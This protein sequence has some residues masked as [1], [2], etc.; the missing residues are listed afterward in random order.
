MT[1]SFPQGQTV[2]FPRTETGGPNRTPRSEI[3][4][5]V[6]ANRKK[7]P[8]LLLDLSTSMDWNAADDNG[9]DWPDPTSRRAITIAALHGLVTALESEDSEAATEQAGGSDERGGLMTHGFANEHVEIGDLNSSN[10]ERRL[11]SIQWGGRT[12]IMPAW[13]AALA[14]YDEEFGDRD[15]AEQPTMLTLV[16]TDGEADDWMDFEPVLEKADTKHVFVVAIIGHGD[17]HDAT[18][19]A[20]TQGAEKNQAQ[21]KFGKKHVEVV[22]FDSVTDPGE[23]AGDLVTLVS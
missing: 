17:K 9:P 20:Y 2:S 23:I 7:E 18:L 4:P 19:R 10:L 5:A 1:E 12:Y 6:S 8:V 22:S 3:G 13:R 16:L 21:D 14:D 15:P 11:N